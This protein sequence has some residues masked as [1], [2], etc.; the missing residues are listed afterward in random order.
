MKG[1]QFIKYFV[2]VIQALKELGNSGT[3]SEVREVIIKNLKIPDSVLNEQVKSGTSRFDNKVAWARFYLAKAGYL[4]SSKRGVWTFTEKGINS[5]L[6]EKEALELFQSIQRTF[7][8]EEPQV[9]NL[10]EEVAP[11]APGNIHSG[12]YREEFLN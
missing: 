1:P 7:H 12:K 8:K 2:P 11:S 10:E 3:P 6:T 9:E 5:T 4:N